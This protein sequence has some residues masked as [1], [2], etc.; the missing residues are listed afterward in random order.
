MPGT[1]ASTSSNTLDR[2]VTKRIGAVGDP[3]EMPVPTGLASPVLPSRATFIWRSDMK[4]PVRVI[5]SASISSASIRLPRCD[6]LTLLNANLASMNSAPATFL[7]PQLA[8]GGLSAYP[9]FDL[10]CPLQAAEYHLQT[11]R[12]R[13]QFLHRLDLCKSRTGSI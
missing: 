1:A 10:S 13:G 3:C 4:L 11:D 2:Y 12:G 9:S 7:S 8:D 6:L 5:K